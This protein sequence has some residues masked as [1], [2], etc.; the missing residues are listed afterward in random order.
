MRGNLC[1]PTVQ[2]T[3]ARARIAGVI[4]LIGLSGGFRKTAYR[5]LLAAH[6][7]QWQGLRHNR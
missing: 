7:S 3:R 2:T 6:P 1:T 4:G 5:N